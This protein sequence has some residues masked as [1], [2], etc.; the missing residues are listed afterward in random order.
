MQTAQCGQ[1]HVCFFSGSQVVCLLCSFEGP[2]FFENGIKVRRQVESLFATCQTIFRLGFSCC[3]LVGAGRLVAFVAF[4][5]GP[6]IVLQS[7]TSSS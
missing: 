6:E 1:L 7:M 2:V 4:L 3:C 5:V